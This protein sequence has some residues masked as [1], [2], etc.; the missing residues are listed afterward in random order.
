[1]QRHLVCATID[2][3]SIYRMLLEYSFLVNFWDSPK[4]THQV[5]CCTYR[6]L[7]ISRCSFNLAVSP[8]PFIKV[9]KHLAHAGLLYVQQLSVHSGCFIC[10]VFFFYL[11]GSQK[12]CLK[13][14]MRVKE[15]LTHEVVSELCCIVAHGRCPCMNGAL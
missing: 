10:K 13:K 3:L 12:I 4:L 15:H 9:K 2:Y 1:M 14:I 11:G 7:L 6:R 5:G 8:K